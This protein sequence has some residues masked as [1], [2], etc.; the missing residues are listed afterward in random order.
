[1]GGMEVLQRI[2]NW[3]GVA[4]VPAAGAVLVLTGAADAIP[5]LMLLGTVPLSTRLAAARPAAPDCMHGT[6]P[7]SRSPAPEAARLSVNV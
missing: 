5:G 1:M 4:L 3:F 2:L 7:A 6:R